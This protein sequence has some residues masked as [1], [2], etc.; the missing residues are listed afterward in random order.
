MEISNLQLILALV[1]SISIGGVAGYIGTLMLTKRM[2]LVGGPLGHLTLPG[3]ALALIYGFDVSLGALVFLF[4]G[5]ALIWLFEKRTKLPL[6]ALTAVVFSSSLA[7]AFLFLPENETVEALIGN[8]SQITPVV[9]I[10]TVFVSLLVFL[11]T[12]LIYRKMIFVGVSEDLAKS[13]GIN[14]QKYNLVYL[15]CI[16]V[17]V[18]LS[19]RIVGGLLTAALVAIPA[20]TSKN[21]S[22]NLTQYSYLGLILGGL[23]G[24]LGVLVF[25]FT[26]IPAGPA[27]II[28]SAVFFLLSTLLKRGD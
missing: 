24:A 19:V 1:L 2:S 17:V 6:E 25:R 14:V 22:D 3:I 7:V 21:L 10:I 12:K 8:I 15:F 28:V 9:V 23:A 26:N 18:A 16:A 20:G 4:L 5:I 13:R 27:I 11:V